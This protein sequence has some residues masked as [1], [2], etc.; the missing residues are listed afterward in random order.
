M[1]GEIDVF[2]PKVYPLGAVSTSI[3]APQPFHSFRLSSSSVVCVSLV[4]LRQWAVTRIG[5]PL[6]DHP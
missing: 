4:A 3:A 2:R 6:K 1:I 5:L